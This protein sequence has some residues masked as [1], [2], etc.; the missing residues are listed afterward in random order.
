[1][2]P[3][4]PITAAALGLCLA[5]CG[6]KGDIH[7]PLFLIPQP[8]ENIRATQQGGSIVLEWL[9]PASYIDGTPLA[10]IEAVEIWTADRP[11]YFPGG[12]KLLKVLKKED[13]AM[14]PAGEGTPAKT[15][16]YSFVPAS[17]DAWGKTFAFGLRVR[18]ARKKRQSE[19]SAI[20]A[21]PYVLV[22]KPPSEFRISVLEDR[23]E[24]RW[25]E[26][27]GNI[28]GTSPARLAGYNIYRAESGQ[29]PVRLNSRP[30]PERAFDDKDFVNGKTYTYVIRASATDAPP[31][32]ESADSATAVVTP[33]DTFPPAKPAGLTAAA[34]GGVITLVWEA[35]RESDLAGYHVWRRQ[36]GR[37]D[38]TRLTERPVPENTYTDAAPIRGQRYEYAVSAVDKA[39]NESPKSLPAAEI[40]KE[41]R[42]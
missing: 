19:F 41:S 36:A 32:A 2:K 14:L 18:D 33:K 35:G 28:D 38:Y 25:A 29:A 42:P 6:R 22:P 11:E 15:A 40:L 3:F 4:R 7:P 31:Y 37:T 26:P 16:I 34:G 27:A 8:A 1:M 23:V 30:V 20:A 9:N 21:T 17:K 10:E 24:L 39:G 5:A 13:W 12:A